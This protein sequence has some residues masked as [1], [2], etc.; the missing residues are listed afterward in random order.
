MDMDT[1]VLRVDYV[2]ASTHAFLIA[3]FSTVSSFLFVYFHTH[4]FLPFLFAAF[5]HPHFMNARAF[6]F[7]PCYRHSNLSLEF[8]ACPLNNIS[9]TRKHDFLNDT[10]SC[11]L[12]RELNGI[13]RPSHPAFQVRYLGTQNNQTWRPTLTSR[14]CASA[15]LSQI[16]DRRCLSKPGGA[17]SSS[18]ESPTVDMQPRECRPRP[19]RCL[20][21]NEECR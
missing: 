6:K 4:S 20:L 18:T 5:R 8:Q 21:E 16:R 7:S 9:Q 10:R 3:V 11:Y 1:A 19:C 17:N 2:K 12:G 15:S 13:P 14:N